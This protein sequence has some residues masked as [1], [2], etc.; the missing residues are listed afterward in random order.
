[1][2]P[3]RTGPPERLDVRARIPVLFFIRTPKANFTDAAA[4][5][6]LGRVFRGAPLALVAR[7]YARDGAKLQMPYNAHP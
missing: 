4:T 6:V 5:P 3:W 2:T 7:G 1:M